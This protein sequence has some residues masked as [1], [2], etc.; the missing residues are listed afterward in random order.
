MINNYPSVWEQWAECDTCH[1][2]TPVFAVSANDNRLFDYMRDHKWKRYFP[3]GSKTHAD[4]RVMCGECRQADE[5]EHDEGGTL[6]RLC[7]QHKCSGCS[8]HGGAS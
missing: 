3:P 2:Q 4:E 7:A 1:A 5:F 6:I 8:L